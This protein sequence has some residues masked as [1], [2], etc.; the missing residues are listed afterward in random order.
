MIKTVSLNNKDLQHPKLAARILVLAVSVPSDEN[1]VKGSQARFSL[2]R[3][4]E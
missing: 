2:E 4:R 3:E 1:C